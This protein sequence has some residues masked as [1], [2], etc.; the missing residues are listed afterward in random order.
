MS[1]GRTGSGPEMLAYS[2]RPNVRNAKGG[3]R[4]QSPLL[5][6]LREPSL[7]KGGDDLVPPFNVARQEHPGRRLT[8]LA[9]TLYVGRV[10]T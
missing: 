4:Q 3:H 6:S 7:T 8:L 2:F 10:V 1:S 5:F 9:N